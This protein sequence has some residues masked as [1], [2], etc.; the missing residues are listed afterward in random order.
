[1]EL[2]IRVFYILLQILSIK[3]DYYIFTIIMQTILVTGG[4]DIS[5][6][7]QYVN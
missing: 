2:R 1:M 7:I 5:A 6:R 3:M 4:V